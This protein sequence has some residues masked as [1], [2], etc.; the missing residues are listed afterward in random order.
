[1]RVP[2]RCRQ[3]PSQKFTV[4]TLCEARLTDLQTLR[5]LRWFGDLP[6]GQRD[7]WMLL[8]GTAMSY[9]V[10]PERLERKL[11]ALAQEA[12]GWH[13]RESKSR[14]QAIFTRAHMAARGEKVVWEGVEVDPQYRFCTQPILELLEVTDEEQRQMRTLISPA[15][16]YRRRLKKLRQAGVMGR[17]EYEGRA[18]WRCSEARRMYAERV[19]LK[20]IAEIIGVSYLIVRSY[21]FR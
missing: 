11:H 18:A 6:P 1:M 9:L 19:S 7:Y 13:E 16:K 21:V 15:E 17:K 12:A 10:P 14:M 2:K 4:E 5:G 20:K 3:E 8:A